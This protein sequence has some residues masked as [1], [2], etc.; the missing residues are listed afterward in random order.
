MISLWTTDVGGW[1]V[2]S[3]GQGGAES[4]DTEYTDVC[5]KPDGPTAVYPCDHTFRIY[6]KMSSRHILRMTIFSASMGTLWSFIVKSMTNWFVWAMRIMNG[7]TIKSKSCKVHCQRTAI[8]LD[9]MKWSSCSTADRT[10]ISAK[11]AFRGRSSASL[12]QPLLFYH[13]HLKDLY[14]LNAWWYNKVK[15]QGAMIWLGT[16]DSAA[17]WRKKE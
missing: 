8:C 6:L 7:W 11:L 14:F 12:L 17:N 13:N 9:A 15:K 2:H 4:C 1:Y 10:V 3:H 5:G 16:M